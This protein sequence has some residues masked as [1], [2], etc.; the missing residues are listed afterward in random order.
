MGWDLV[1]M[2]MQIRK[3]VSRPPAIRF[4]SIIGVIE[5]I[6]RTVA[7]EHWSCFLRPSLHF[8]NKFF[9]S[10]N[11]ALNCVVAVGRI[12]LLTL[13]ILQWPCLGAA[14]EMHTGRHA[15]TALQLDAWILWF[16]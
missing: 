2:T 16:I 15:R 12:Q 14:D 7:T 8:H 1:G 3:D 13:L 9:I 4:P 10:A 6:I 5:L 11:L